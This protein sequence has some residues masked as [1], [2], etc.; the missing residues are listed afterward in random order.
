MIKFFRKI[1][2]QLLSQN[3]LS[4]YFLYAIGEIVLVVVGILIALSINNWNE[5]RKLKI[6]ESIILKDL[7]EDLNSDYMS[8]Q[9]NKQTLEKQLELVDELILDPFNSPL[10]KT[11]LNFIR[12][13]VEVYPV[14]FE[15]NIPQGI[16][17][18]KIL[19]SLNIYYRKEQS[20]L[21]D[22]RDYDAVVLDL[23]RPYLRKHNI[24]NPES[25]VVSA[26]LIGDAENANFGEMINR[27]KL[28]DLY[29][30][31]EFGQIMFELR[32][33]TAEFINGINK[34]CNANRE[35]VLLID[36]YIK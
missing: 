34:Q 14:T 26:N 20:L 22:V 30:T 3:R 13:R 11:S 29:Q 2:Q 16:Y 8:F 32:I 31:E 10:S 6:D 15:N 35:L 7:I 36:D 23:V 25:V 18:K 33:K 28:V 1:R 9:K 4:K 24:H 19:E 27:Q 5:R 12:Y 17:T 21:Q